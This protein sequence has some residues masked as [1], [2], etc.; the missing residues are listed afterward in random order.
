MA[1]A[2]ES[3]IRA[4]IMARPGLT[5]KNGPLRMGAFLNGRQ[6]RSP[7]HGAYALLLREPGTSRDMTAE[8]GGPSIA[9]IT[10]HVYAGTIETA[11]AA[12]TAL[13]NAFQDLAG[14]PERCGTTG[15]TVLAAANFAEPG[16]VPMPG[17]GGEQ[18]MFTTGADFILAAAELGHVPPGLPVDGLAHDVRG[19]PELSGQGDT[20]LPRG[21]PDP[22]VTD[23]RLCQFGGAVAFS[24]VAG[25]VPDPVGPVVIRGGPP[26]E[27][28][29][30]PVT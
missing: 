1:V 10:A 12:A 21:G 28:F 6:P 5:G 4:W 29:W 14:H 20:L 11:E 9:R 25:P 3:A 8:P 16:Y 13:C 19:H 26:A 22:A 23:D 30:P 2:A 15:I 27:I 18:H 17:E 7:A 24:P